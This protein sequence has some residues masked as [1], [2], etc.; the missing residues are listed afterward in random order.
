MV[1]YNVALECR[2]HK[3]AIY[4]ATS[5]AKPQPL[6]NLEFLSLQIL[7]TL[8]TRETSVVEV[9]PLKQHEFDVVTVNLGFT[10]VT[11]VGVEIVVAF[12]F[13]E[14]SAFVFVKFHSYYNQIRFIDRQ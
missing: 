2:N 4:S 6:H 14:V 1:F 3:R 5:I 11:N 13:V 10:S 7:S 8:F 12:P 9:F